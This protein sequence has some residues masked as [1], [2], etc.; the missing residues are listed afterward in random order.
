MNTPS[1]QN[2]VRPLGAWLGLVLLLGASPVVAADKT[3]SPLLTVKRIFDSG[4]FGGDGFSAR[5]LE[6][7][8]GYT[9]FESSKD[10]SGCAC[11]RRAS[12]W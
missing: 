3:N 5:W 12:S 1:S 2:L 9:T 7:S 6:D 4:D 8:S 10:P 11:A